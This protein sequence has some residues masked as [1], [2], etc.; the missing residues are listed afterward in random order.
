MRQDLL[1]RVISALA[2]SCLLTI[3]TSGMRV[4]PAQSQ[5]K[6]ESVLVPI[7]RFDGTITLRTKAGELRNIHVVIRNWTIRRGEKVSKFPEQG[8]MIVQLRTGKVNVS[9]GGKE[10][11]RKPGDFWPVPAGSS[12][13]I[14]VTSEAA[15]LQ[16]TVVRK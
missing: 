4:M 16:T 2:I 13:G 7:E 8:F 1:C 10:A 15:I 11:K 14:E 5:Q 3:V 12:M 6:V 9:I